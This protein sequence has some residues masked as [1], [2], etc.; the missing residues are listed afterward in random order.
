MHY[1]S[2]S[3]KASC[4]QLVLELVEASNWA[5]HL[6]ELWL[7]EIGGEIELLRRDALNESNRLLFIRKLTYTK[8][9]AGG[10]M[11]LQEGRT[12]ITLL[13]FK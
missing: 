7:C 8:S 13:I 10:G 6:G 11:C 1:C 12:L 4:W 2:P 3:K 5:W 9:S